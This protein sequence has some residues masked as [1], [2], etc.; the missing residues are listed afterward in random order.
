[1]KKFGFQ[2]PFGL[3]VVGWLQV[4]TYNHGRK[5]IRLCSVLKNIKAMFGFQKNIK[6]MVFSCLV[7]L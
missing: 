3:L 5:I 1:M 7:V 6:K 4:V 2:E